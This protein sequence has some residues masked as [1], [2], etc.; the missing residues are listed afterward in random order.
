IADALSQVGAHVVP[1]R[2]HRPMHLHPDRGRCNA[3]GLS[4]LGHAE[5]V[6]LIQDKDSSTPV[7]QPIDGS[8]DDAVELR[9]LD[10][11]IGLVYRGMPW[12][13]RFTRDGLSLFTP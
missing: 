2:L 11:G 5:V 9:E 13:G 10:R 12:I 6:V 4:D 7:R 8:A 3:Q 1:D